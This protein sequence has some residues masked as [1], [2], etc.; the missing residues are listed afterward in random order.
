MDALIVGVSGIVIGWGLSFASNYFLNLQNHKRDIVKLKSEYKKEVQIFRR[1]KYEQLIIKLY[2]LAYMVHEGVYHR[3]RN[4]DLGF[5]IE[6]FMMLM[7]EVETLIMLH[8]PLLEEDYKNFSKQLIELYTELFA[9]SFEQCEVIKE[10]F[11]REAE[12]LLD[13]VKRHINEYTQ[14][15]T[16]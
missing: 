2:R 5:T 14:I 13:A 16:S 12:N 10:D 3:S 8:F 9:G 6:I 4:E 11:D 7:A 1:E 15:V